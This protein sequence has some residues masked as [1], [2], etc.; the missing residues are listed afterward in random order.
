[1]LQI[2]QFALNVEMHT[3][4]SSVMLSLVN[5]TVLKKEMSK[6]IARY[7]C[8]F[9]VVLVAASWALFTFN[10]TAPTT[11]GWYVVYANLILDGYI[12]YIDFE[13]LYPPLYAYLS[14]LVVLM[15]GNSLLA[16]RLVGVFLIVSIAIILFLI[17]EEIV[18]SWI[19]AAGSIITVFAMQGDVFYVSYDYH[20]VFALFA[21]ISLL[22]MVKTLGRSN[23]TFRI[24]YLYPLLSGL[25]GSLALL[26]RPQSIALLLVYF[27]LFFLFIQFY[28]KIRI[29]SKQILCYILGF[30]LPL[31]ILVISLIHSGAFFESI[32]M[33][34]FGGT[35]GD[36]SHMLTSWIGHINISL[37]SW[38]FVL[39]PLLVY[40]SFK[41]YVKRDGEFEDFTMYSLLILCMLMIITATII[42]GQYMSE[43]YNYILNNLYFDW[44]SAFFILESVV[45]LSIFLKFVVFKSSENNSTQDLKRLFIGGFAIASTIGYATSGPLCY[46]GT[47]LAFGTVTVSVLH[48]TSMIQKPKLKMGLRTLSAVFMALLLITIIVPK[49]EVPYFWWGGTSSPYTDAIHEPDVDYFN[50]IKMSHDEKY[51]YEDFQN[52]AEIYLGPDDKLYCYSNIP[53]FYTIA[54]KTPSVKSIVPWFDVSRNSTI[55]EDLEYLKINNPKMIVFCDHTMSAVN[56]HN[57]Y[58]GDKSAHLELYSW[59]LE[60]MSSD[61]GPYEVKSAYMIKG[62]T[63]YLMVLK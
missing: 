46:V 12:P 62:Y 42:S 15:F 11:E 38:P 34:F 51:M 61:N 23:R 52:N 28:M 1:M 59:L 50:G 25:T 33:V 19:S 14:A 36:L 3:L 16:F 60:C 10:K 44:P 57:E 29:S 18:P 24:D 7:F 63:T 4:S 37:A 32:E 56:I 53:I 48:Y 27:I 6:R 22:F 8:L 31:V 5:T 2:S 26:L 41:R 43:V 9:V 13:F 21:L 35:K 54:G 17:F 39:I 20:T 30:T 40:G 47:A 55:L 45:V 58:Y 49:T